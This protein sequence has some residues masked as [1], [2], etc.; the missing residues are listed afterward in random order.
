MIDNDVLAGLLGAHLVRQRWFAGR[1]DEVPLCKVVTLDTLVEGPPVLLRAL[2]ET[3]FDGEPVPGGESAL[4]QLVIGVRPAG[5]HEE[6]LSGRPEAVVAMDVAT[7]MGPALVYDATADPELTVALVN[8]V[9][10]GT[11]AERG[12]LVS[13][14]STHTSVVFDER[15]IM[16]LFRRIGAGGRNPDAEI[17]RALTRVGFANVATPVA[18]WR[19]EVND[20]ALVSEFLVGGADGFSLA[21]TSLRD[22]YDCRCDPEEAGGDFAPDARR[23]GAVT[24][25]LHLALAEAFPAVR[26]DA[27]HWAA[28]MEERF[29]Q[30]SLAG[31]D[32]E[33]V[34]A[35]FD[36]LRSVFRAGMAI[37]SH[38]DYHLGQVMRTDTGWFVLDFEGEPGSSSEERLDRSSPLRD[39]AGMIRSFHYVA[40]VALR[41]RA[42][43]IDERIVSLSAAWE[44]RSRY[45]F[46]EGYLGVE[47]IG[48]LLP[49]GE[50]DQDVVFTAFELDK[51]IYEVG[52]EQ[53]HRPDWVGIPLAAVAR[54]VGSV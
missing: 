48:A 2:V 22:L 32:P 19:D 42:E 44:R 54:I 46:L 34:H 10:P 28:V 33:L 41:E 12:R 36:R 26:A 43:A 9:F 30:A 11:D 20:Y 15:L 38:G 8:A 40:Q 6:F 4:Y 18:E 23:L 45:A 37:R 7:E 25:R 17:T 51:A 52:Y 14:E 49:P 24:A 31:I 50:L 21:L 27:S 29:A 16:K 53:A 13:T 1:E 5:G 39:A 3:V 47:G 35:V